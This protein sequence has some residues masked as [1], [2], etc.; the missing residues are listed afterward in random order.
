MLL[1]PRQTLV[2]GVQF[3]NLYRKVNENKLIINIQILSTVLIFNIN[4]NFLKCLITISYY[5]SLLRYDFQKT[6]NFWNVFNRFDGKRITCTKIV[7]I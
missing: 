4:D 2:N 7:K 3:T 6:N 5:N 1:T